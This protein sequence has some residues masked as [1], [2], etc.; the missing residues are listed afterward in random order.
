VAKDERTIQT[1]VRIPET[2]PERLDAVAAALSRPGL[3]LT[4]TD[5]LRMALAH[6][7]LALEA[8]IKPGRSRR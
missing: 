1:A 5:V 8:E 4:R 7:L 3:E 2:W 6:G